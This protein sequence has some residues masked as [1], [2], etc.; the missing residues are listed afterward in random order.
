[1][2][3]SCLRGVAIL[4]ANDDYLLAQEACTLLRALGA[5]ICGPA[6]NKGDVHRLLGERRIDGA[7]LKLDMRDGSSAEL[8]KILDQHG[9]PFACLGTATAPHRGRPIINGPMTP[10]A[11]ISSLLR[12][13][14]A[15]QPLASA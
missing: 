1:M 10:Y 2:S 11:A 4:V 6:A 14:E 8:A 7:L 3:D 5:D 12:T 13:I 15:Q 9:I